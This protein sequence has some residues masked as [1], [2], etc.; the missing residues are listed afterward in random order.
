MTVCMKYSV[1][2]LFFFALFCLSAKN[3]T[4]FGQG[5]NNSSNRDEQFVESANGTSQKDR[6]QV[7][8]H[9]LKMKIEG[10]LGLKD[11]CS[12][13]VVQCNGHFYV[14]SAK[15]CWAD[16]AAEYHSKLKGSLTKSRAFSFQG[17][18]SQE[19]VIDLVSSSLE[20]RVS[21]DMIR[22]RLPS[23]FP[24]IAQAIREKRV[25]QCADKPLK[26]FSGSM[27]TGMGSPACYGSNWTINC[28]TEK[29]LVSRDK[30]HG[31]GRQLGEQ[32]Y[33]NHMGGVSGGPVVVKDPSTGASLF[34]G[35]VSHHKWKAER[36][37]PPWGPLVF[38]E[39]YQNSGG[40]KK[41]RLGVLNKGKY[42]TQEIP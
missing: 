19:Y 31:L 22:M 18:G 41:A 23:T 26:S 36:D 13:A 4:A 11:G 9:V 14:Y 35:I 34:L 39:N 33:K 38:I 3:R 5:H 16:E 12:A 24:I 30:E 7:E 21:G 20:T 28:A 40:W 27:V 2:H 17:A 42:S 8:H 6:I 15:H 10:S 32:C 37:K 29:C 25:L 1:K